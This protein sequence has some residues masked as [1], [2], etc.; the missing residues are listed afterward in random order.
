[1]PEPG[2][3]VAAVLVSSAITWALR[4]VP[5]G[6][7][8][9]LRGSKVVPYLGAHMPVGVMVILVVYSVRNVPFTQAP[10]G[11]ATLLALT[12]TV[13]LHLWR[14]N[15]VLSIVVGTAVNVLL[16]TLVFTG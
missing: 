15:L 8:G 7:L 6:L 10:H 11:A 5:F 1:V 12:A 14:R 9:P 2:Y 4:A 13:G 3:L 16:A